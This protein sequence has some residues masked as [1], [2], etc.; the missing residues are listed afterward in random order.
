MKNIKNI[1][2][3]LTCF[4]IFSC[5]DTITTTYDHRSP[6]L[7]ANFKGDIDYSKIKT[8]RSTCLDI[9][10]QDGSLSV[11]D[12]AKDGKIKKI[13]FVEKESKKTYFLFFQVGNKECVIV[14]GY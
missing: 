11:F 7:D 6:V 1:L 4:A 2:F 12:A 9:E 13:L 8:G 5:T 3:V 14:R 10:N